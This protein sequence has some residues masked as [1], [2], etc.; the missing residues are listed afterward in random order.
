MVRFMPKRRPITVTVNDKMQKRYR[1]QRV[2]APGRG[3]DPEFKPQLSP[4][5][6]LRLGVF[7]GKYLTDC[8][9]E[10]PKSWFTGAKLASGGAT[11]G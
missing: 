3:F 4:R 9:R 11:A 8:R 5:E 1:Y 2:A 7:C 10:F 6:M